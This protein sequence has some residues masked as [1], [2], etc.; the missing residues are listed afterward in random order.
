MKIAVAAVDRVEG[1]VM[2][3]VS[4]YCIF[5]LEFRSILIVVALALFVPV[6]AADVFIYK[7]DGSVTEHRNKDF[8]SRAAPDVTETLGDVLDRGEKYRPLVAEA[9]IR[10]DVPEYLIMAVIAVESAFVPEALS[11]DSAFG[12][13]QLLPGTAQ[14]MGYGWYDMIDPANAIDAGTKLLGRHMRAYNGDIELVLSAYNAGPGNVSKY[15]GVPPFPETQH[16]IE[17]IQGILGPNFD[18]H[19]PRTRA[20][21][22]PSPVIVFSASPLKTQAEVEAG[23][24]STEYEIELDRDKPFVLQIQD[25]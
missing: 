12:L 14:D 7:D 19:L 23:N 17:S 22:G 8:R 2:L 1:L 4:P 5:K 11:E 3:N 18:G 25:K 16:Y 10:Y 20:D 24:S 9:A 15:G 6:A 21:N 13:M